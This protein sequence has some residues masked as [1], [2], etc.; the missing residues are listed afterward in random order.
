MGKKKQSTQSKTKY[1]R[2]LMDATCF[3]MTF[4]RDLSREIGTHER[5]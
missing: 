4:A 1:P 3:V 2:I 5:N